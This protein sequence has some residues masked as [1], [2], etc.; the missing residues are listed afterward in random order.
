MSG[1]GWAA[2]IGGLVAFNAWRAFGPAKGQGCLSPVV[3]QTFH[4]ETPRGRVMLVGAWL[5]LSGWLL[6]HWCR[7]PIRQLIEAIDD[8]HDVDFG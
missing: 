8:A 1:K 4:T 2:V 3:R 6:P 7:Q 5:L